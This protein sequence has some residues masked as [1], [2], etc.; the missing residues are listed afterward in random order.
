M[1][2]GCTGV[3]PKDMTNAPVLEESA[4]TQLTSYL[5]FAGLYAGGVASLKQN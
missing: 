1:D 3:C 5:S 4:T 2:K